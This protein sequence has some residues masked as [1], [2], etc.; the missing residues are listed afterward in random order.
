MLSNETKHSP[1]NMNYEFDL[2]ESS[3]PCGCARPSPGCRSAP[4][5]LS[6]KAHIQY[7]ALTFL[8]F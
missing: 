8:Y 3:A 5:K 6:A 1:S 2:I 4:T 7:R